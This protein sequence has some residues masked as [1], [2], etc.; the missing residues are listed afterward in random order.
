MHRFETSRSSRGG[1]HSLLPPNY[2]DADSIY[3]D[4][5]NRTLSRQVVRP[6]ERHRSVISE[7]G[8]SRLFIPEEEN[9]EEQR[10]NM[11]VMEN[12]HGIAVEKLDVPEKPID[13][14][15]VTPTADDNKPEEKSRKKKTNP[16]KR[17]KSFF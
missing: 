13:Q 15:V 10:E 6:P 1:V 11:N 4:D 9:K 12:L 16:I 7:S 17:I 8:Q 2:G 3:S 14:E 5:G